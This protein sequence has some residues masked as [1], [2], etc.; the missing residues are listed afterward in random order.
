[1]H[2]LLQAQLNRSFGKE[3]DV[4]TAS[5]ELKELLSLVDESY[6]VSDDET[7]LIEHTLEVSSS[8]LS[9]VNRD[10]KKSR[11]LLS[12]VTESI[13]DII[14]YKDMEFKYIGC[15][16]HFTKLVGKPLREI[17][18][19][20]DYELFDKPYADLFR[21]M[22]KKM[23][24]TGSSRANRE[25]VKYPDGR[26]AYLLTV[27]AP[28]INSKGEQIGLVGIAHDITKEYKL[29]EEVKSQQAMLLQQSRLAAMGE[30]IGNIAHQ[31]RQPLNIIGLSTTQLETA[32]S[33]GNLNS[34]MFEKDINTINDQ[35]HYMSQTIDDFR[36]YFQHEN[37]QEL[38]DLVEVLRAS[39]Q[40]IE[41]KIKTKNIILLNNFTSANIYGFQNEL[42]QV[43]I[44]IL[45]N[46][47]FQLEQL[48]NSTHRVL[49]ID[50]EAKHENVVVKI[51]DNGG[52][53]APK[54]RSKLF[55]P[56]FTTKHPSIGTG[57]GLYMSYEIIVKHFGGVI[58]VKN[59][60]FDYEGEP[61]TWAEFIIK[62]PL[63]NG[64]VQV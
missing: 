39:L 60:K 14:F 42:I 62:I 13:N 10:L 52:G 22:D 27:K 25:W 28:L 40:L 19:K 6:H 44:N 63:D 34:E 33:F 58:E 26:D 11:D 53:I 49:M 54:A 35:I 18:G 37:E 17:I 12:N 45:H 41:S 15:N 5:P 32:R 50:I 2:R 4:E 38:F 55:E 31:W 46:A 59:R 9:K 3:F 36:K 23:F 20:S 7:A 64:S 57:I 56:Y 61:F 16:G 29:E 48:E 47:I 8:E 51:K 30:M 24:A 21:D 43:F 1:M